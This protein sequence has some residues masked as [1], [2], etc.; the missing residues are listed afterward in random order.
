M[1]R[2]IPQATV[3]SVDRGAEMS[4]AGW[5]AQRWTGVLLVVFLLAH[6]VVAHFVVVS[7]TTGEISAGEVASRLQSGWFQVLDMGLL[8]LALYHGFN[9]VLRVIVSA[10]HVGNRLYFVL[11]GLFWIIGIALTYYGV[12]VFRAFLG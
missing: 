3:W 6:L 2:D 5:L 1:Q 4:I 8:G 10:G 7:P 11:L 12:L 9:G